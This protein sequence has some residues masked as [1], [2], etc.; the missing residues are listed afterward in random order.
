MLTLL[1]HGSAA[2]AAAGVACYFLLVGVPLD[3]LEEAKQFLIDNPELM[4]EI[5]G[6]VRKCLGMGGPELTVIEGG[7]A[8]PK[9]ERMARK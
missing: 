1:L 4:A 8:T 7:E 5:E 6:K 3:E 9:P 2:L